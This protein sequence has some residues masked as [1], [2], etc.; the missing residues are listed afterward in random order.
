VAFPLIGFVLCAAF[1][2]WEWK[3][4][5]LYKEARAAS[6]AAGIPDSIS[7]WRTLNP[8]GVPPGQNA[9]Y[10]YSAAFLLAQ[11]TSESSP[12]WKHGQWEYRYMWQYTS[13]EDATRLREAVKTQDALL[14]LFH[15]AAVKKQCLYTQEL[16]PRSCLLNERSPHLNRV[17]I[18]ADILAAAA[19]VDAEDGHWQK[20]LQRYRDCMALADSFRNTPGIAAAS[21]RLYA[22]KRAL[23]ALE[24]AV[25]SREISS[26]ELKTLQSEFERRAREYSP[27]D[28]LK[29]ELILW[30]ET[31]ED[32]R[33]GRTTWK[34]FLANAMGTTNP[35][36]GPLEYVPRIMFNGYFKADQARLTNYMLMLIDD[37]ESNPANPE[38]SQL[39]SMQYRRGYL[40]ASALVSD[41]A[42]SFAFTATMHHRLS[43]RAAAAGMALCRFEKDHGV[44]PED[45]SE[46]VP[47]YLSADVLVDDN[48]SQL[49]CFKTPL[50][51]GVFGV[52]N[53][54][55]QG[56]SKFTIRTTS[57]SE[58]TGDE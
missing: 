47:D 51:P 44:L 12:L 21:A 39:L 48:G 36:A 18:A 33:K 2:V 6:G 8:V 40:G 37:I 14:S 4:H 11:S 26:G 22:A 24:Y 55:I 42:Q 45:L 29:T 54:E 34:E 28:A 5:S 46:L 13:I 16:L 32:F 3:A 10:E 52:C 23:Q 56:E 25:A 19:S 1:G 20:A 50:G 38:K 41:K 7:A 15:D 31:I 17:R 30:N 27:V 58:E 57:P 35:D 49:S 53:E 9:A 43:L